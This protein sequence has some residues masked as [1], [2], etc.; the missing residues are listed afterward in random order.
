MALARQAANAREGLAARRSWT[1]PAKSAAGGAARPGA[2]VRPGCHRRAPERGPPARAR[3]DDAVRPGEAAGRP[4]R[5]RR[6]GRHPLRRGA[7][8][9]PTT[10]RS[11]ASSCGP[12]ASSPPCASGPTSTASISARATS[13]PTASTTRR[14]SRRSATRSS[15]NPDP[16]CALVAVG[17]P[18]AYA[19]PRRAR[20]RPEVPRHRAAAG[21]HG[22]RRGPSSCRYARF[23][24]AGVEHIPKRGPAIIVGN[25][26]SYFDITAMAMLFVEGGPARALPRQ[27]GG[28][29][30]AG[31]R[32]GREGVRRH[33][34]RPRHR[35]DE[36][37]K[38]AVAALEAGELVAIMPQ[39]TI[40]RG[41]GVLR[42][43]AQ[44]PLG[45]G[46]ARAH[47]RGRRSSRS[48]CGAPRRC[49]R[50]ARGCRTC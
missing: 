2:A 32:S 44:G 27:E 46:P 20:R 22:V 14:C 29:R 47:S 13:T 34:R 18:L 16:G 48:G 42:S 4:A 43:R 10:A 25:H 3:H 37:L 8:T 41:P 49:G 7:T 36:P 31:R 33:P 11:S 12:T 17:A 38:A 1:T 23:D 19:P 40:P 39:G 30:R 9:A 24:I 45:R 6:R 35:L 50:A 5:L 15:V 26:R 28:L 21:G